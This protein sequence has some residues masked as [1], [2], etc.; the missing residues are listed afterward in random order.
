M[1]WQ[2]VFKAFFV[3]E[4]R[5]LLTCQA[6]DTVSLFLSPSSGPLL[7]R[8]WVFLPII[9]QYTQALQGTSYLGEGSEDVVP[10]INTL[11]FLL[12]LEQTNSPLLAGI[13]H[14]T[15]LAR[16]MCVF[17]AG[18]LSIKTRPQI[19]SCCDVGV[20]HMCSGSDLFR[21]ERVHEYLSALLHWYCAPRS[22]MSID[23]SETIPGLASFSD[24]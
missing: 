17:L 3:C 19:F 7:P 24:L 21:E 12:L 13:S 16:I 15:R 4:G 11:R 20:S 2:W 18:K 9:S 10:I 23:L 22:V 8:D 5:Q 6:G 1:S 14:T